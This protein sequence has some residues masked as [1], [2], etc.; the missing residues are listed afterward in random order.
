MWTDRTIKQ[1]AEPLDSSFWEDPARFFV[2]EF[3]TVD[4]KLLT[5]ERCEFNGKFNAIKRGKMRPE[6]D[7]D[8]RA[9]TS[10][11]K[12]AGQI[13][14]EVVPTSELPP[15]FPAAGLIAL[16]DEVVLGTLNVSQS[17]SYLFISNQIKSTEFFFMH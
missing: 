13:A 4:N 1:R 14:G 5:V 6:R 2:V 7:C 9:G 10:L 3:L 16:E 11:V 12:L 8:E 17:K 15:K